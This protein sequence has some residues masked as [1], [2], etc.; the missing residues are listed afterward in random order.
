MSYLF[1]KPVSAA[2]RALYAP[3]VAR[4][5]AELRTESGFDVL[6]TE[7]TTIAPICSALVPLGIAC[8]LVNEYGIGGALDLRCRSSVWKTSVRLANAPGLIDATYRGQVMAA[9]DNRSAADSLVLRAGDRYFQLARCD[10]APFGVIMVDED[11]ELS[12]T[13]R[14]S[15]GFGSTGAAGAG[16]EATA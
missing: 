3:I 12:S 1:I 6:V 7:D 15:G 4:H 14:G 9:V 10:G 13:A 8:E 5:N 16:A 11:K 2:A